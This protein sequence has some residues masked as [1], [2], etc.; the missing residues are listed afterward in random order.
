MLTSTV[1]IALCSVVQ[2]PRPETPVET[3][4]SET[5]T[6]SVAASETTAEGDTLSSLATAAMDAPVPRMTSA[7]SIAVVSNY[8][9]RGLTQTN[10]EPAVQAGF[11]WTHASGFYAGI[12][13][14]NV[15]WFSDLNTTTSTSLEADLYLGYKGGIGHDVTLDVGLLRYEYPGSYPGL[16]PATVEPHTTEAYAALA[17]KQFTAK[18]SYSLDDTFG[19]RDSQGTWYADIAA[20][21]TLTDEILLGLHAGTQRY[22]G[23]FG[24]ASNDDLYSYSDW[25]VSLSRPIGDGFSLGVTYTSTDAKDAG[26]TILGENIGDEQYVL[27]LVKAF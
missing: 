22:D 24:G 11:G 12:W 16:A 2:E 14:S 13:G 9:F 26:Y 5:K 19:V 17:W 3:T 18:F 20:T 27:S 6:E 1:L 4:S 8:V 21:F 23:E 10:G 7:G 15:S 25:S